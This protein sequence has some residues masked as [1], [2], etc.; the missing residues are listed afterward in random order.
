VRS[1]ADGFG[2]IVTDE[3]WLGIA[4]DQRADVADAKRSL[5]Q[6][7]GCGRTAKC[8]ATQLS[9]QISLDILRAFPK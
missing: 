5:P 3:R 2:N 4:I 9:L 1:S 8:C 6:T 7:L